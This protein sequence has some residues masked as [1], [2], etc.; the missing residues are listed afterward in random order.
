MTIRGELVKYD[1]A[2]RGPWECPRAERRWLGESMPGSGRGCWCP[3]CAPVLAPPVCTAAGDTFGRAKPWGRVK[4]ACGNAEVLVCCQL[5]LVIR[6]A[7]AEAA[8]ACDRP[9]PHVPLPPGSR[10]Q[11]CG[12]VAP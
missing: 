1:S 12:R 2:G 7:R 5:S 3:R 8:S 10:T 9:F 11:A 4:G 6:A